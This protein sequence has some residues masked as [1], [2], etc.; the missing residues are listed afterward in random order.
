MIVSKKADATKRSSEREDVLV[1]ILNG[2]PVWETEMSCFNI[3]SR[4]ITDLYNSIRLIYPSFISSKKKGG[5]GGHYDIGISLPGDFKR[6]EVKFSEK[7]IN[8][9]L[10]LW[11][12]WSGAVEFCQSQL[13]AKK[14][15][16]LLGDCTLMIDTWFEEEIKP[17]ISM[18][19]PTLTIPIKDDY[20]KNVFDMKGHLKDTAAGIFLRELREKEV[21]QKALQQ[22][23]LLFEDSWFSKHSLN[24]DELYLYIK[25]IIEQKDYW[26]NINK[27]GAF[28]IEGFNVLSLKYRGIE[29]KP[30]G[31][32]MF[33][34]S[35]TLQKKSGGEIREVSIAW[36]LTWKNGGQSIQ[37]PNFLIV[38]D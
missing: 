31:G 24:H 2:T 20:L 26:L 18:N 7:P 14:A 19:C 37:N 36:K 9:E 34:Y 29:Q 4:Q 11:E 10:L 1:R 23:W 38:S 22:R 33:K 15:Q 16:P 27:N 30:K 3:S 8:S 21:L 13:K 6:I 35:M 5:L 17:F 25:D 28:W 12:P 32:S